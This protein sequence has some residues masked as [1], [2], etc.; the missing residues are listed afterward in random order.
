[1]AIV[2][3]N[4]PRTD[5]NLGD[6]LDELGAA[7]VHEARGARDCGGRTFAPSSVRSGLVATR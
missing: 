5:M 3:R 7:T 4:T 2:V 6:G 1:M